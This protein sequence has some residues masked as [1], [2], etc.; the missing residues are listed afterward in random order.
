MITGAPRQL[1]RIEE[2]ADPGAREFE[3]NLDGEK[4]EIFVIHWH[5]DWYAYKNDCPH[6]GVNLNWL[7]DQFFDIEHRFIQCS[8]HGALFAPE[9]GH[10][11]RGPCAGESLQQLECVVNN[12]IVYVQC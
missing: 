12:G 7:P 6:T 1:C 11:V 4:L 3:I 10:C 5:G 9:S 2:I 8:T